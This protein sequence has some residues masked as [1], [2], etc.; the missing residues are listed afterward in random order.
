[1]SHS[2]PLSVSKE[3]SCVLNS[4]VVSHGMVADTVHLNLPIEVESL[5]RFVQYFTKLVYYRFVSCLLHLRISCV[6]RNI[7][8]Q[9]LSMTFTGDSQYKKSVVSQAVN[10][11]WMDRENSFSFPIWKV[12]FIRVGYGSLKNI[13]P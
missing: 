11:L 12:L 3:H 2:P 4:L 13:M 10:S 8:N 9:K 5:V 1:M 6:N 7:Q